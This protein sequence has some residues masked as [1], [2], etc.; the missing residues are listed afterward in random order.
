MT[1][2]AA[3]DRRVLQ[4]RRILATNPPMVIVAMQCWLILVAYCGGKWR[5]VRWVIR[6]TVGDISLRLPWRRSHK[7]AIRRLEDL[8][9]DPATRAPDEKPEAGQSIN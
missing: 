7:L 8:C 5:A 4:L 1:G 9:E 2:R 6:R 3:Y